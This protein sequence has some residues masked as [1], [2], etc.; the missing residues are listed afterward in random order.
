MRGEDID[1]DQSG[2]RRFPAL[3]AELSRSK[4]TR[5]R[6]RN[7]A[8]VV[9]AVVVL[10][11]LGGLT[12]YLVRGPA[13][14]AGVHPAAPPP[15]KT[16]PAASAPAGSVLSQTPGGALALSGLRGR[17]PTVLMSLPRQVYI[18]PTLDG[19]YFVTTNGELLSLGAHG[20]LTATRLRNVSQ[21][22][23]SAGGPE[24]LAD[25]DKYLALQ[26]FNGTGSPA[27]G[28]PITIRSLATQK[29]QS[30]GTGD[31]M[32]G[33]PA[34]PG[35][36]IS[37]PAAIVAT[38]TPTANGANGMWPDGKVVIRDAGRKDVLLGTAA[39]FNADA[40]LP[41]KTPDY[42]FP[43]PD[44]AGDK[45]A[46]VVDPQ[47]GRLPSGVVVVS[48]SGH[49]LF[50]LGRAGRYVGASWSLSGRSLAMPAQGAHGSVLHIWNAS[51]STSAQPFPGRADYAGCSWSPDGAW[52]LCE[53]SGPH[54]SGEQWAVASAAGGPMV[55]TKGPGYPI[56]WLPSAGT[57]G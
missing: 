12:A 52:I 38:S 56:T 50:A 35:V 32:S 47:T 40:G 55:V 44:P 3:D 2:R 41:A 8:A 39:Q 57:S 54:A 13:G 6:L 49:K 25:H 30:L 33:D 23:W 4:M 53:V 26:N 19:R 29:A 22:S 14:H 27:D 5:R 7:A 37:V 1:L 16:L 17:A 20:H 28:S 51:G 36:I 46:V 43:V 45:I 18:S 31:Q 34:A 48:R 9:A 15:V 10:A 11:G 24:P 21:T 42:L